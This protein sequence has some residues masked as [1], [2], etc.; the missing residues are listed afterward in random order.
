MERLLGAT[1]ELERLGL[2]LESFGPGAVA[3]R[4][5]ARHS[6]QNPTLN[7]L[8]RDIADDLAEWDKTTRVEEKNPA[9]G[10]HHG[11]SRGLSALAAACA[12]KK[13]TP[14]CVKWK[15]RPIPVNA[16]MVARPMWN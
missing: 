7:R 15:P 13:W 6:G 16:I 1:E 8:V 3:V 11:L 4:E 14:C 9:C 10:S 2:A 5:D 12:P